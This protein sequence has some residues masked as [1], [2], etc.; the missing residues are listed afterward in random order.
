[1][2]SS[3]ACSTVTGWSATSVGSI[4]TGRFAVISVMARCDVAPEGQ[5]VAAL[6]HGD[7]EPDAL[8]SI[9]AEHRLRRVGGAARDARDVAQANDP[10]VR[11]EVDGQDVLLG[12]ERARDA[13][14]DLL[15]PGLHDAR[16]GDGVL[17]LQRGDQRGAV[18]PEARQLLGRELDVD[19]L[20]LRPEN[21]D[22]RDVR[23]LEELLA[24]V[25]DV[26]P[27]LPVGESVR[28]E[29]VDDAVGVAELIVEAGADDVLAAACCGC[30]PPSCAP[31]TRCPAPAPGASSPSDRRRSWPCPRSCSSSGSRG[32]ASPG[33]CVRCGR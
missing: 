20:V 22:L 8:L 7:G 19:A 4:P 33:A 6:A 5:D 18:D 16:R 1:M 13:D 31:G 17:G 11:D 3:T 24:D 29:A 23:Q 28:G 12:L 25:V 30:R 27:Q 32:S 10:A 9:D 26:V 15:V 2:N 21:V 14:E